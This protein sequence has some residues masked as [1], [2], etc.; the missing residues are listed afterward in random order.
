MEDELVG[1]EVARL[2]KEVGFNESCYAYYIDN[3]N[4]VVNRISNFE[5]T[6]HKIN[7]KILVDNKSIFLTHYLAPTQS[8]LHKWLRE[9]HNIHIQIEW[10]NDDTWSAKLVGNMFSEIPESYE[11]ENYKSY[12][13]A[14]EI[15][16]LKALEYIKNINSTYLNKQK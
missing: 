11:A 12:E 4:R 2:A 16:L 9:N 8:L 13:E 14:L 10:W 3:V 1:F 5:L 7:E 6:S 15:A